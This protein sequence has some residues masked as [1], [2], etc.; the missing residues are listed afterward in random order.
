MTLRSQVSRNG[1]YTQLGYTSQEQLEEI[2]KGEVFL[3]HFRGFTW[4]FREI[5]TPESLGLPEGVA[6]FQ[7][8]VETSKTTRYKG[9]FRLVEDKEK[10]TFCGEELRKY[11]LL[12]F[13][14]LLK[15][16]NPKTKHNG[17]TDFGAYIRAIPSEFLT[18]SKFCSKL[19]AVASRVIDDRIEKNSNV[20]EIEALGKLSKYIKDQINIGIGAVKKDDEDQ[21]IPTDEEIKQAQAAASEQNHKNLGDGK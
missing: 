5:S 6:V 21:P 3:A 19:K 13:T 9:I 2:R 17:T 11:I 12:K 20:Q 8:Y 18:D 1:N 10:K 4:Y 14:N 16:V 15:D 7:Y